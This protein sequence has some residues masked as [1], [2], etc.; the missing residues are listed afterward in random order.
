MIR[1]YFDPVT[2]NILYTMQGKPEALLTQ[3]SWV[4]VESIDELRIH[5]L[6]VVDGAIVEREDILEARQ[7]EALAHVMSEIARLRRRMVTD[8]PGQ[9]M[10]YL[11][12]E[13]QARDYVLT[14]TGSHP[15]IEAE[16]GITAP[17]KD[18]V[19]QVI[20]NLAYQWEQMAQFMEQTRLSANAVI[21]AAI[22]V[23]EVDVAKASFDAMVAWMDSLV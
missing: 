17:T 10:L 9:E 2:S 4:D 19:A 12:K 11:R 3:G 14:Q 6:R 15:L 8:L 20:L 22:T 5:E 16:V 18:E 13:T 1:V 7:E 23:Q 21:R